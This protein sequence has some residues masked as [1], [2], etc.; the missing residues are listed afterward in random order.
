MK[1][2]FASDLDQTLIYSKRF[3][4]NLSNVELEKIELVED[5]NENIRSYMTKESIEN[6]KKFSKNNIFIPTTTRTIEQYTR[7]FV[8]TEIIKPEYVVVSNGGNIIKKGK[9]DIEWNINIKKKVKENCISG[10]DILK[11]YEE[12]SN[13]EWTSDYREADEL[14]YYFIV[15]RDKMPYEKIDIFSKWLKKNGWN[16]SIQKKKMYFVPDVIDKYNA[17]KHIAQNEEV[18]HI[19]AAGDSLLDLGLLNN[20]DYSFIPNH[21]EEL[22]YLKNE[23]STKFKFTN[24]NGI[25]ASDDITDNIF[26]F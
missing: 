3:L 19:F 26:N 11:K 10:K 13:I 5:K 22:Q 16:L 14:F 6:I 4:E 7:I 24:K 18:K 17:V 15:Q 1:N 23:S 12:I 8:F 25:F 20:S 2:I 9:V 21:S